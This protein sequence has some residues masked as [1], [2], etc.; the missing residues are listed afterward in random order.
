MFSCP[1]WSLHKN[2]KIH[3]KIRIFQIEL[4]AFEA[5]AAEWMCSYEPHKQEAT[6]IFLFSLV[7]LLVI[8]TNGKYLT[9]K[10]FLFP[11]FGSTT[12]W[13]NNYA[14]FYI[15]RYIIDVETR[16]LTYKM[17]EMCT[18]ALF[19]VHYHSF[20]FSQVWLLYIFFTTLASLKFPFIH[21]CNLQTATAA[22]RVLKDGDEPQGAAD[23]R[24]AAAK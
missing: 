8:F 23:E 5:I 16:Y 18:Y 3:S 12:I 20:T 7:S 1:L 10:E 14:L 22:R 4:F 2:L 15:Y 6:K 13:S 24:T 17:S 21:P 19:I 9:K 11:T